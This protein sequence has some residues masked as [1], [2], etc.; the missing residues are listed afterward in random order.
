VTTGNGAFGD[1]GRRVILFRPRAGRYSSAPQPGHDAGW[2]SPVADLAQYERTG[3]Q[4]NY[5]HR[6]IVNAVALAF[7]VVL[8]GAGIWIA[9]SMAVMRKNQD[10]VLMGRRGCGVV[11]TPTTDRWSGSV[12]DQ[13]R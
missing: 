12:S 11:V 7:T 3:E 6:M 5:R 1:D 10:C 9:E 2:D 8:A 4:D 13:R